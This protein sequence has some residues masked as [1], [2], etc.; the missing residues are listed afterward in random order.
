MSNW[1]EPDRPIDDRDEEARRA[2]G[3]VDR[4]VQDEELLRP[5]DGSTEVEERSW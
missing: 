1:H 2:A 3:F 5:A 4:P